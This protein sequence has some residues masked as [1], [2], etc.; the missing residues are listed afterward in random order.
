MALLGSIFITLVA[1]ALLANF[2]NLV[3]TSTLIVVD[4]TKENSCSASK[5]CP[6]WEIEGYSEVSLITHSI[7]LSIFAV[8]ITFFTKPNCRPVPDLHDRSCSIFWS[9]SY[10]V[11]WLISSFLLILV[12]LPGMTSDTHRAN[13]NYE[14]YIIIIFATPLKIVRN[15]LEIWI[16]IAA[17]QLNMFTNRPLSANKG[18][19][20]SLLMAFSL[21]IDV[22]YSVVLIV[23]NCFTSMDDWSITLIIAIIY[24]L[25]TAFYK[26]HLASVMFLKAC[27]LER[28]F[29]IPQATEADIEIRN[30]PEYSYLVSQYDAI[31]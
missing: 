9:S 15:Q 20:F 6:V 24:L 1:S 17:N 11:A 5:G 7:E 23:V 4:L 8:L 25:L 30:Q 22:I 12:L 27:N 31:A 16:C 18:F 28:N 2:V 14:N 21:I 13:N 10:M 3:T 19:T 29:I 26:L